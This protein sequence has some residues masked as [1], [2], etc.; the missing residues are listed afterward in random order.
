MSKL[1]KIGTKLASFLKFI[2]VSLLV[3]FLLS[4]VLYLFIP[5]PGKT[6]RSFFLYLKSEQY[7]KAYQLID[8]QYKESRG[9]LSRFSNEYKAAA[10]SGTRT[11]KI[12]INHVYRTNK[13]NQYIVNV[14][15][16]VLYRGDILD[17]DGSYL[18]EKI[19]GKGWR[20]VQNVSSQFKKQ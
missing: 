3:V 18:L 15:V 16:R 6:T 10:L 14:T 12:T 11:K 17:T 8:G 9:S 20:I 5:G 7:D 19:P 1:Q 2:L 4:F 13:A